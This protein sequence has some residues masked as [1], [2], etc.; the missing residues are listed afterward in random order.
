MT[1]TDNILTAIRTVFGVTDAD[2]KS[3]RRTQKLA[4][5]RVTAAHYSRAFGSYPEDIARFF[6]RSKSWGFQAVN[7]ATGLA[8]ADKHYRTKF[9]AVGRQLKQA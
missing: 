7:R 3:P 8:A 5:A 4:E 1:P 9:E 6:N 2:L